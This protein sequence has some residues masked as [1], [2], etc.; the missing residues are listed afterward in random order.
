MM[1]IIKQ[2]KL[3]YFGH[4][5]IFFCETF[6]EPTTIVQE[7]SFPFWKAVVHLQQKE[8]ET[9]LKLK[10]LAKPRAK[11]LI[12]N[13][14]THKYVNI[15][16]KPT[17]R[18]VLAFAALNVDLG[19]YR[20]YTYKITISVTYTSTYFHI[21]QLLI[22]YSPVQKALLGIRLLYTTNKF[23]ENV[24]MYVHAIFSIDFC[25]FFFR[26]QK[27]MDCISLYSNSLTQMT[28]VVSLVRARHI[29]VFIN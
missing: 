17:L 20:I 1:L 2:Q 7:L 9:I 11:L 26:S 23:I 19:S 4:K 10:L 13:I 24:C 29:C 8:Q 6:D 3:K 22:E 15:T 16:P 27:Q 5:S 28:T 14:S 25:S 12:S 18:A 21:Y